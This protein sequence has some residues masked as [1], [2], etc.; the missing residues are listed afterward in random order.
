M[1]L[2]CILFTLFS[3]SK[4]LRECFCEGDATPFLAM[5]LTTENGAPNSIWIKKK[6]KKKKKGEKKKKKKK[7]HAS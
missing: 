4:L 2:G 5:C 6:K 7:R 1:N 3:E